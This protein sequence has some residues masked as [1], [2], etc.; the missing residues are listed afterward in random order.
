MKPSAAILTQP[1][2]HNYGG[3]IQNY[4]LQRVLIS[5]G[6]DPITIN[7]QYNRN[8][9]Y[10][11]RIKISQLI[12]RSNNLYLSKRVLTDKIFYNNWTFINKYIKISTEI[13][14]NLGFEQFMQAHKFDVFVVGSDQ[15][16]RPKYSPNI[17]NYFLDFLDSTQ[18]S[19][20]CIA[21]AASF[22][23][24]AWEYSPEET[25]RVRNLIQ[26]FS[27]ISVREESGV[28]LCKEYLGVNADHV[29]DPTLLL[30]GA[31]YKTSL[32]LEGNS[33]GLNSVYTYILDAS[34]SKSQFIDMM[35]GKLGLPVSK[36]QGKKKVKDFRKSD[37]LEEL[38]VP[39]IEDWLS[40]FMNADFIVTDSFHGTVFSILFNKPF[41]AI[42]NSERGAARFE[43]LLGNL[44]I[45][46]RMVFEGANYS[47]KLL[48]DID[49]LQVN[50]RLSILRANSMQFLKKSLPE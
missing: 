40:G 28:T 1:L 50:K 11:Y 8:K 9:F 6:C 41:V 47:E 14:S 37:R 12:R 3:I 33:T 48:K 27:S 13:D 45:S 42:V 49:Y 46:D 24:D 25:Q 43:S 17:Y 35:A 18:Q 30:D 22:G 39:P 29:L 31:D 16:W 5:L 15:T 26:K 44:G 36:S 34:E 10:E 19:K 23:T 7:R 2:G 38:V 20:R 21:Y 32:N 4:A